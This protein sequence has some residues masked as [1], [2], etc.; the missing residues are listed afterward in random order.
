MRGEIKPCPFCWSSD[1]N[2][3][4]VGCRDEVVYQMHCGG[5]G[6]M[7]VNRAKS[8]DSAVAMWNRRANW[9]KRFTLR[10]TNAWCSLRKLLS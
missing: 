6:I 1:C 3:L 8:Y 10:T 2:V 7:Q 4:Q 9:W 5:C